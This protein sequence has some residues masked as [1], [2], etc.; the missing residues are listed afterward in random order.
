MKRSAHISL[1]DVATVT[2]LVLC[3][4]AMWLCEPDRTTNSE[5]VL[6]ATQERFNEEFSREYVSVRP[7]PRAG[8]YVVERPGPEYGDLYVPLPGGRVSLANALAAA[9]VLPA[10]RCIAA[11][12]RWVRWHRPDRLVPVTSAALLV[13]LVLWRL[14][15]TPVTYRDQG[16]FGNFSFLHGKPPPPSWY[17]THTSY[18]LPV[19]GAEFP[20]G[21]AV[22]LLA[23]APAW[24]L[25]R[26]LWRRRAR[27]PAL[28]LC[29]ACGYDLRA[30]PDRCPEC[31]RAR[32]EGVKP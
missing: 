9:L 29:P 20:Y 32:V 26:L 2:S 19:C 13:V 10:A 30:T 5:V 12:I 15:G 24:W 8:R 21:L 22:G 28:N 18:D 3:A 16:V 6:V 1:L 4:A 14:L 25:A 31:G 23:V 27:G 17:G 7:A 11:V